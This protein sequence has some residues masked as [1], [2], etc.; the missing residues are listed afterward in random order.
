MRTP[1]YLDR[2]NSANLALWRWRWHLQGGGQHWRARNLQDLR[3]KS[4]R[5]RYAA[6]LL[7]LREAKRWLKRGRNV[8]NLA[9]LLRRAKSGARS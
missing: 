1:G 4:D 5:A 9:R 7:D 3:N 8:V 6:L 2:K